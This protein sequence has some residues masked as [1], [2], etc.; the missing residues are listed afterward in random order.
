M[1][2]RPK[3]WTR[4]ELDQ[5]EFYITPPQKYR[6][7]W[8]RAYKKTQPLYVEFGCGKGHFLAEKAFLHPE[9]NWL[10]MDMIDTV[11]GNAQRNIRRR[12]GNQPIDNVRL[13]PWD[14]QRLEDV[15]APPDQIEQIYINF[16]NP[17][18]RHKQHKKR[19]TH[20]NQ[21]AKYKSLLMPGGEIHFK[22]DDDHLFKDSLIYFE[23]SGFHQKFITWDL[24]QNPWPENTLTEHEQK[25]SQQGIPIKAGI[26]VYNE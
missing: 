14:I 10:G 2:L 4:S 18:P 5:C 21:L 8:Q 1:H 20:P 13:V 16:C 7:C 22:T 12:F 19:L 6:G 17:W 24:H 26:F 11:L 25:F 23:D 15:M 3:P 9:K